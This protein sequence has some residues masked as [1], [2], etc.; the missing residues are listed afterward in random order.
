M[1]AV[2]KRPSS[3]DDV[4]RLAITWRD[5]CEAMEFAREYLNRKLY[6]ERSIEARAFAL[7]VVVSYIR[8]F[9]GNRDLRGGRDPEDLS[10]L[11]EALD[12]S[13]LRIHNE[14][15]V[16]RR[17][18]FAHSDA[19]RHPISTV[20]PGGDSYQVMEDPRVLP[21]HEVVTQLCE[22]IRRMKAVLS[23]RLP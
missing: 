7:A 8:P 5:L 12:E 19:K 22:N 6:L 11:V 9:S 17:Q 18:V 20:R 23:P 13:G 16:A 2:D 3:L 14:L 4:P 15:D 21:S 10:F 1:A